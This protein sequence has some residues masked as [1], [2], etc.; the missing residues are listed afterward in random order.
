[1]T[2]KCLRDKWNYKTHVHTLGF[3]FT[4]RKRICVLAVLFLSCI[5]IIRWNVFPYMYTRWTY[6]PPV[7]LPEGRVSSHIFIYS[8]AIYPLILIN[9]QPLP[10]SSM[11]WASFCPANNPLLLTIQWL[12]GC[13]VRVHMCLFVGKRGRCGED[14]DSYN[15]F[16]SIAGETCIISL[17]SWTLSQMRICQ[18]STLVIND[19]VEMT[20]F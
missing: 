7:Y 6:K 15:T 12:F 4:T 3:T 17:S 5:F 18:A 19:R 9:F 16:P 20:Q 1:M 8:K 11:H 14:H 13:F 2:F 10:S